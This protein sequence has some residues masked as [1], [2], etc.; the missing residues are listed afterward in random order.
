MH[1]QHP[2]WHFYL[3]WWYNRIINIL[4]LIDCIWKILFYNFNIFFLDKE[5][6]KKFFNLAFNWY[7]Y[8][9]SISFSI[10]S[11]IKKSQLQWTVNYNE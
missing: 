5:Q 1:A 11:T 10:S 8:F 4:N 9:F 3:F 2:S 7:T 6:I